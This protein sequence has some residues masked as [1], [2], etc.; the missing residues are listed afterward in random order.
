MA[1]MQMITFQTT[2]CKYKDYFVP[3]EQMRTLASVWRSVR[4]WVMIMLKTACDRLL[5]LFMLVTATVRDLLPSH[6]RLSMSCYNKHTSAHLHIQRHNITATD[7]LFGLANSI[8]GSGVTALDMKQ[9]GPWFNARPMNY[10]VTALGKLF[11]P[12]CLS[13]CKCLVVSVD[14]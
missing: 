1:K 11:T 8:G 5:S 2:G 12:T 9:Q 14:S 4:V 3:R 10:E 6:I 13:R 7:R